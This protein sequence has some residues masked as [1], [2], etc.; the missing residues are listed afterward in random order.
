MYKCFS[1]WYKEQAMQGRTNI[2]LILH[3]SCVNYDDDMLRQMERVPAF[4]VLPHSVRYE[5]QL[6]AQ[7]PVFRP[8]ALRIL[9]RAGAD[10]RRLKL[11]GRWELEQL[12][13][14]P[15]SA[16]SPERLYRGVMVFWFGDLNKQD[17][18]L[19]N[20]RTLPD[21]HCI[22]MLNSWDCYRDSGRIRPVN[23]VR[24][25]SCRCC[26]A[27]SRGTP[28]PPPEELTLYDAAG[29]AFSGREL[30]PVGLFGANADI[31]ESDRF[32]GKLVKLYK[33]RAL[34]GNARRKLE[35]L[36]ALQ[37][38]AGAERA[39]LEHLALPEQLIR[40]SRGDIAGYTMRKCPGRP[41]RDYRVIGWQGH[42]LAR[43]LRNLLEL[44]VHLHTMRVLV[45]DLSFNNVLIDDDDRVSLVDCDSFQVFH[46]PGGGITEPFRHPRIDPDCA[47]HMLQEPRHE[48]FSFAVL[49]FQIMFHG[50][51]LRPMT[52]TDA[53]DL[54]WNNGGV[55]LDVSGQVPDG[56]TANGCIL[57]EWE[58]CPEPLRILFSDEFHFREDHS[59]GAWIHALGLTGLDGDQIL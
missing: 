19:W 11:Q 54:T 39:L 2:M 34:S 1:D 18:F 13:R 50:D 15:G 3:T 4:W 56:P 22:L 40:T 38:S 58:R 52:G 5:L 47:P 20:V 35:R 17:E 30:T 42:D 48:Y 10:A 55:P 25:F 8:Q 59:F 16:D 41:L 43:I 6:L 29:A 24:E 57:R 21:R 33:Q 53:K 26:Q 44:L 27:L 12:Y 7:G 36:C 37:R 9:R 28:L 32:P 31:Y 49:L 46:Y 23:E 45:N 51:P 14:E